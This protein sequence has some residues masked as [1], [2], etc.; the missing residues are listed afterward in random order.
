MHL[1]SDLNLDYISRRPVEGRLKD[2]MPFCRVH[3]TT[4]ISLCQLTVSRL[5]IQLGARVQSALECHS[6]LFVGPRGV[7]CFNLAKCDR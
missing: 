5:Y 3:L 2:N 7:L 1:E 4:L 6:W